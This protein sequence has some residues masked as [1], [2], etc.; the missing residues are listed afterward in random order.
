MRG[1]YEDEVI[2]IRQDGDPCPVLQGV[3]HVSKRR[4]DMLEPGVKPQ[5]KSGR[6]EN[7]PLA[8]PPVDLEGLRWAKGR[9]DPC[10]PR[11]V[12]RA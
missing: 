7:L 1:R 9:E 11:P 3:P 10:R 12:Q 2:G 5:E 6:R 8:N 4:V